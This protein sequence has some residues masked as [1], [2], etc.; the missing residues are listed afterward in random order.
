MRKVSDYVYNYG[1]ISHFSKSNT[2]FWQNSNLLQDG[3][4]T[5]PKYISKGVTKKLSNKQYSNQFFEV[6]LMD[7]ILLVSGVQHIDSVILQIH[8]IKSY[9]KI[10]AIIPV[11]YHI[12]LLLIYFTHT[13]L[14]LLNPYP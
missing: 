4:F 13:G 14:Y 9:Y 11:L 5:P 12:S 2:F 7:N 6:Q 3:A 10:M 1:K 8:T